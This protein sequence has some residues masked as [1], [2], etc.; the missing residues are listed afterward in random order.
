[1]RTSGSE[2][3]EAQRTAGLGDAV[4][5]AHRDGSSEVDSDHEEVRLS[6]TIRRALVL[7]LA[8][9]LGLA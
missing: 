9:L 4:T 1:M 7:G 8:A 6:S 5:C 2:G 3:G